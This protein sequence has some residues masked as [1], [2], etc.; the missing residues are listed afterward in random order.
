MKQAIHNVRQQIEKQTNPELVNIHG[1][2]QQ[3]WVR[4]Q[5]DRKSRNLLK[6]LSYQSYKQLKKDVTT[7]IKKK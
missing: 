5:I 3:N 6:S 4:K 2:F 7:H 1:K